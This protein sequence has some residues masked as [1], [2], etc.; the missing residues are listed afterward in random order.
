MSLRLCARNGFNGS[1][2]GCPDCPK[3]EWTIENG[4]VKIKNTKRYV[5]PLSKV[6]EW[7]LKNEEKDFSVPFCLVVNGVQNEL[8]WCPEWEENGRNGQNRRDGLGKNPIRPIHPSVLKA[9]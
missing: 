1:A 3:W 4:K 5:Q 2:Q 9:P 6:S 8:E 7:L